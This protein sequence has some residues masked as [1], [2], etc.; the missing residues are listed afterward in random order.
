VTAAR[1]TCF[2]YYRVPEQ[3]AALLHTA[4]RE[5]RDRL[6]APGERPV[7]GLAGPVVTLARRLDPTSAD[8]GRDA[9][10]WLE[11]HEFDERAIADRQAVDRWI[12]TQAVAAG[13]A[14]LAVDGR[15]VEWF[16]T[17]A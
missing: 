12:E 17:C 7:G 1:C 4:F 13:V 9:T 10:T 5:L 2:V 8:R 15:R 6:Q 16:V 11:S 14:A 3:D